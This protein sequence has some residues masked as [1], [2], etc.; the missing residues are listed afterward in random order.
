MSHTVCT[1]CGYYKGKA[2]SI[3]SP[4]YIDST[5]EAKKPVKKAAAKPKKAVEPKAEEIKVETTTVE[6][7]VIEETV[8]TEDKTAE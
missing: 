4:D 5:I 7:A 2:V 3:K 1:A 8:E 6:E